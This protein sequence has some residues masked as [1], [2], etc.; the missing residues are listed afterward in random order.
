MNGP[1]G[2]RFR[3][4]LAAHRS[5]ALLNGHGRQMQSPPRERSGLAIAAYNPRVAVGLR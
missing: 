5:D 2:A 1:N 4:G 3:R